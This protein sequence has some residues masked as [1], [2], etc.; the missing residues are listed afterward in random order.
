METGPSSDWTGEWKRESVRLD[1]LGFRTV[2]EGAIEAVKQQGIARGRTDR[3]PAHQYSA[4]DPSASQ[5]NRN[6]EVGRINVFIKRYP[7]Q[8][9]RG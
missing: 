1:I 8:T 3:N 5:Y 7:D 2:C 9:G 4:P 6:P